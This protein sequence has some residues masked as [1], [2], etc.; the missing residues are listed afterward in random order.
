MTVQRAYASVLLALLLAIP[1]ASGARAGELPAD[2]MQSVMWRD[3][4]ERYLT[5]GPVVF[6]ERIKVTVPGIVERQTQVPVTLDARAVPGV[7]ELVVLADLNPIPH[8]LT[9][10]PIAAEPYI[11]LRMKVEQ[12]TAVRAAARTADGTWHVGSAFLVASGGGC[13]A[14]AMAR[15]LADWSATVGQTRG[16]LWREDETRTRV[17]LS[18]RHPMDTG[19]ARDNTP[20]FFIDKM[21][22]ATPAGR[23]LAEVESFE[24]VSEDPTMTL[25]VALPPGES[26]VRLVSRDNNGGTYGGFLPAPG[27]QSGIAPAVSAQ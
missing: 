15:G 12:G 10:R 20:A 11:S 24:P 9:L 8:V 21:T 25:I 4:A 7:E 17:R 19:L 13:S 26:G 6:D 22:L 3:M 16:R 27:R 2:P 14:P 1:A 5:G 23:P 18:I